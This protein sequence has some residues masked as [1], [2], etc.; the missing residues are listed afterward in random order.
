MLQ[1]LTLGQSSGTIKAFV[2][3]VNINIFN[4]SL[5]WTC[6]LPFTSSYAHVHHSPPH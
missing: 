1:D 6:P 2:A 3:V 4:N 5:P